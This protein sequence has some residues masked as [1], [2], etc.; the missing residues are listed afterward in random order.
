MNLNYSY[1]KNSLVLLLRFSEETKFFV[2]KFKQ[3]KI[4]N[5]TEFC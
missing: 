1:N 2:I 3:T 5:I 4:C